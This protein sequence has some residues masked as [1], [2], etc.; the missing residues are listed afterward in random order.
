MLSYALSY[1]LALRWSPL[2]WAI[3][4]EV[5]GSSHQRVYSEAPYIELQNQERSK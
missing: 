4:V 1:T 2:S 5:M 3:L